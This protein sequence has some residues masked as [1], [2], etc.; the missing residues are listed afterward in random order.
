MRKITVT[1]PGTDWG[2][3][4]H[5]GMP[6]RPVDIEL[7]STL[8]EFIYRCSDLTRIVEARTSELR[9]QIEALERRIDGA[10]GKGYEDGHNQ[11]LAMQ[12]AALP[13]YYCKFCG[14]MTTNC[15]AFIHCATEEGGHDA[16]PGCMGYE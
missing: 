9:A 2:G 1:E 5:I 4:D 10:Y 12:Y 3:P 16:C 6:P 15:N 11:L 14:K 7:W 13:K 8:P